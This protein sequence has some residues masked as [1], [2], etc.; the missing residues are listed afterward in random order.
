VIFAVKRARACFFRE[1]TRIVDEGQG[2]DGQAAAVQK[3]I[4]KARGPPS[5]S[6]NM[7]I[8]DHNKIVV[9]QDHRGAC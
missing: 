1:A 4:S 3:H 2:S 7:I 8:S 5:S 6:T 9:E